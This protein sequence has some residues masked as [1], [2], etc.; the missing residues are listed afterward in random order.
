[1][2]IFLYTNTATTTSTSRRITTS[3]T[4]TTIAII[5]PLLLGALV[6]AGGAG[7][8]AATKCSVG[9]KEEKKRKRS[10]GLT[11]NSCNRRKR[12]SRWESGNRNWRWW[13]Q[14]VDSHRA[15]CTLHYLLNVC[16]LSWSKPSIVAETQRRETGNCRPDSA[17]GQ[18]SSVET[19]VR[20]IKELRTLHHEYKIWEPNPSPL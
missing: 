5:V 18:V 8:V 1:V 15:H 12:G 2:H 3:T 19:W 4:T 13:R 7:V 20:S 17:R 11:I 16:A 10:C 14:E 6:V 9:L